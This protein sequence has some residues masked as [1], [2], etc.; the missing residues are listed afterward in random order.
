MVISKSSLRKG[1]EEEEESFA[2][3][4]RPQDLNRK[5]PLDHP[6]LSV[7]RESVNI[8][9]HQTAAVLLP[10]ILKFDAWAFSLKS[11]CSL[12]NTLWLV[13]TQ[14]NANKKF[15]MTIMRVKIVGS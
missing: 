7:F 8:A 6:D 13:D 9:M 4:H 15:T 14:T 12:K 1:A 10:C 2:P 3:P 5:R 11:S